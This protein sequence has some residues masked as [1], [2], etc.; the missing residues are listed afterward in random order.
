MSFALKTRHF[1]NV[2]CLTYGAGRGRSLGDCKQ[3]ESRTKRAIL[4]IRVADRISNIEIQQ[5]T[6]VQHVGTRIMEL[7]WSW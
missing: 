7:N 2:F 5:Q 3:V 1:N 6:K 4:V